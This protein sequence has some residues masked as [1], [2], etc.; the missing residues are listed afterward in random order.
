MKKLL[1]IL[2]LAWLLSACASESATVDPGAVQTAIA[3]TAAANQ[4]ATDTPAPTSTPTSTPTDTPTL[5]PTPTATATPTETPTPT[6]DLRVIDINPY[7]ILLAADDLPEDAHYYL[8]NA[9]WISPHHN[10]EIVSS[11]GSEE[12]RA[13]L[14]ATGRVDGWW[15]YYK[16]GSTTVIAPDEIWDNPVLFRTAAGAQLLLTEYSNCAKPDTEFIPVTTDLLIGDL[17]NVCIKREMQP[18][19]KYQV[20]LLIEFSYRNISHTVG[21][22]GLEQ[23]VQL[24]Y[25]AAIARTLLAK[26]EAMPLSDS[27]TFEP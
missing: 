13:Y 21:G 17:T 10:Y 4:P 26:L 20:W 27:V 23:D 25:L 22:W 15:V 3:Q 6:P 18:S 11:M 24:D 9:G 7:D 1:L 5:T 16:L 19:G 2:V 14:E 12:G 8:P